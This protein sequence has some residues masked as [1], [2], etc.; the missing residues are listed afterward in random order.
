[1]NRAIASL[2]LVKTAWETYRRDYIENFIPFVATL[3]RKKRYAEINT[4]NLAS[5]L[6]DFKVEF[7]L[8]IPHH[9]MLTILDRARKRDLFQKKGAI[10]IPVEKNILKYDFSDKAV[11][12]EAELNKVLSKFVK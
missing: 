1:M 7:G 12:K 3:T 4:A 11:K 8:S 10:L 2:A 6:G 5:F 9:P